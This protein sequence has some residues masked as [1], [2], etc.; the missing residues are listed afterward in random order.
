M[1]QSERE[2]E[3]HVPG[4]A[5]MGKCR[6]D[7]LMAISKSLLGAGERPGGPSHGAQDQRQDWVVAADGIRSRTTHGTTLN[8][9]IRRKPG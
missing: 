8:P 4:R 7:D 5:E 3:A 9:D 6:V 1:R 2:R